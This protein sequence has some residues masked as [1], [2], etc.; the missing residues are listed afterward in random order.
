[1]MQA[2]HGQHFPGQARLKRKR[3]FGRVM[4][5][6]QKAAGKFVVVLLAPRQKRGPQRSR[7]GLVCGVSGA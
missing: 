2:Y 7:L 1:M 6:Q 5:R 3:E 4:Y